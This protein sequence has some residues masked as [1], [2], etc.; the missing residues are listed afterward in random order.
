MVPRFAS[1]FCSTAQ[2]GTL[3]CFYQYFKE[4]F[5]NLNTEVIFILKCDFGSIKNVNQVLK[6]SRLPHLPCGHLLQKEKRNG[7][8]FF[9]GAQIYLFQFQMSKF[10][11][12]YFS[13][14]HFTSENLT[15]P[16]GHPL[17]LERKKRNK[18]HFGGDSIL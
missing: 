10:F 16:F 8:G 1:G 15:C 4:L 5:Q 17:H 6:N 9:N 7:L 11:E 13:N 12:K 2:G 14:T 3:L 18:F